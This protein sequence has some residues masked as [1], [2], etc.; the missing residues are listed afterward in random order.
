M[1]T[2]AP[3]GW[4]RCKDARVHVVV[5]KYFATQFLQGLMLE[6][7]TLVLGWLRLFEC[8]LVTRLE[9]LSLIFLNVKLLSFA[10]TH[11]PLSPL[12]DI[13]PT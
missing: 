4:Q 13:T 7:Q 10:A 9:D 2:G 8:Y 11:N 12:F 6:S 1:L 5:N 3:P